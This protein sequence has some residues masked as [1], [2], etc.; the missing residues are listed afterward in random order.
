MRTLWG[1]FLLVC[2]SL[3][4]GGY[5]KR[6][7]LGVREGIY[8]WTVLRS[9]LLCSSLHEMSWKDRETDFILFA[10]AKLTFLFTDV[11]TYLSVGCHPFFHPSMCDAT[12]CQPP[13]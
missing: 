2:S 5:G 13:N 3:G 1:G 6:G 7:D 8:L 4:V 11:M 10:A 12:F 9:A